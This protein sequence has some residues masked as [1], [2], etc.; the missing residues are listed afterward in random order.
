MSFT[1]SYDTNARAMD[2]TTCKT[3]SELNNV[4]I[5]GTQE[6]CSIKTSKTNFR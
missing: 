2:G 5:R 1:I 6:K 3:T 4:I